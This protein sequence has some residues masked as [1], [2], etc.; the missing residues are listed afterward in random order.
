MYCGIYATVYDMR[1]PLKST[2]KKKESLV[3]NDL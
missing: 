1:Y 2:T 3:I